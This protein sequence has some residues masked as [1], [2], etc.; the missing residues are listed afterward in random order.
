MLA[1]LSVLVRPLER[2]VTDKIPKPVLSFLSQDGDRDVDV[3]PALIEL[4]AARQSDGELAPV[5][6]AVLRNDGN[7][8]PTDLGTA[9]RLGEGTPG[10]LLNRRVAQGVHVAGGLLEALTG[11]I[12]PVIPRA[13]EA[14]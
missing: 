8:R 4:A 14:A 9:L 13:A 2:P 12:E 10:A 1:F 6:R 3:R 11:Q 5:L 7:I